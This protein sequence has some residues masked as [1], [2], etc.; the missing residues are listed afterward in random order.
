AI[1]GQRV[2]TGFGKLVYAKNFLDSLIPKM[3]RKSLTDPR[4][5]EVID[6]ERLQKVTTIGAFPLFCSVSL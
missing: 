3:M 1:L 5:A 2:D 6:L 4:V